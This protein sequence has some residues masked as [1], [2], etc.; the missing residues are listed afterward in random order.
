[1]VR[2]DSVRLSARHGGQTPNESYAGVHRTAT[3]TASDHTQNACMHSVAQDR[4]RQGR[5]GR[6]H[7]AER[8]AS[9]HANSVHER[10]AQY[11]MSRPTAEAVVHPL[12]PLLP[13]HPL[14]RIA[15]H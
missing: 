10:M 14:H 5:H 9:A 6:R 3:G 7:S 8:L 11:A 2:S 13:L 4:T 15:A 1:M 12:H